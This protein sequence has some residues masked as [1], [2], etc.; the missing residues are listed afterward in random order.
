M[1]QEKADWSF[2]MAEQG[3]RD[4][5]RRDRR[6]IDPDEKQYDEQVVHIDRV[7]RVVKGGRRFHFRALTAVGDHAGN[8]GIGVAKGV[9]VTSA[10][11]KSVGVAKKNMTMI[12]L[13]NETIPHEAEA[14]V[15][16]A[17]I[18]IKPAAPGTGLKAGGVVR[19]VLEVAGVR[20]VLSKSL[21]S[22]NKINAAYATLTALKMIEPQENWVTRQVYS[23]AD[24][25]NLE[26]TEPVVEVVDEVKV[27]EKE[28]EKPKATTKKPAVKK[29]AT[30]PKAVAKPKK[31]A[32]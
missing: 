19:I 25:P 21:G 27:E 24:K 5:P 16:G 11:T 1:Q 22:S 2:N 12:N 14:K 10:V 7:A 20:N 32:K 28:A 29:A 13:Y 8:I 3:R 9:D 17:H 30:K 23:K 26:K 31:D 15:S 4:Q 18:L 6:P